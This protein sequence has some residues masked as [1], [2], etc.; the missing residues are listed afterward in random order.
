MSFFKG[1]VTVF[2]KWLIKSCYSK[3]QMS[4]VKNESL[5]KPREPMTHSMIL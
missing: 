1:W 4:F 2:L 3:L 5:E